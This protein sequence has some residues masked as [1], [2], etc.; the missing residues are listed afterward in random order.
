MLPLADSA[1]AVVNR[2][3]R[4]VVSLPELTRLMRESGLSVSEAVLLR[5]LRAEPDR[6]RVIEPWRVLHGCAWAGPPWSESTWVVPAWR[7]APRDG[8]ASRT[9]ALERLHTT[10]VALGWELD[11]GSLTDV[12]RWFGMVVEAERFRERLPEAFQ[13]GLAP[14]TRGDEAARSATPRPRPQPP[15]G[16]PRSL[17]PAPVRPAP[18]RERR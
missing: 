2:I 1:A 10:L 7:A 6:F 15:A 14:V 11:P 18:A 12:A 9:R 5:S 13:V 16:A 4:P 17:R 3:G 8:P